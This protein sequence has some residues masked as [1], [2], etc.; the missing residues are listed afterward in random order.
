MIVSVAAGRRATGPVLGRLPRSSWAR[1]PRKPKGPESTR[2][3]SNLPLLEAF[4]LRH[5]RRRQGDKSDLAF[6]FD[7]GYALAEV[8]SGSVPGAVGRGQ[9]RD[10]PL[11]GSMWTHR[12]QD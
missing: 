4:G 2:C 3:G 12:L 10:Y 8:S 11:A 5:T 1:G 6:G 7:G 9:P